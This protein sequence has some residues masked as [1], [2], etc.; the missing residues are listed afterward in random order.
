MTVRTRILAAVQREERVR[1]ERIEKLRTCDSEILELAVKV[2]ESPG[3]A[4][5]WLISETYPVIGLRGKAPVD[6]L[7]SAKGRDDVR[8]VLLRIEYGIP[9]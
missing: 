9:P 1:A 3:E 5:Q 6:I 2:L 7:S 4:G 8:K